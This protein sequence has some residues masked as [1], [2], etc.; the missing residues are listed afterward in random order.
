MSQAQTSLIIKK[1]TFVI[2]SAAIL[3][4]LISLIVLY[5]QDNYSLIYYG[6]SVSHLFGA[7]KFVDSLE[8]GINQMGTVWLPLPHLMLLPFSLVDQL[9]TTGIAGLLVSLPCHAIASVLIYK[10]I[11]N[12]IGPSY[13]ALIGGFLYGERN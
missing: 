10:I 13:V 7:R 4:G 3:M 2:F 6:D 8:P 9:Y 12:Q 11:R 5:I 1:G